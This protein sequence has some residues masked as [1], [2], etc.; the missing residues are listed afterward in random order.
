MS[1]TVLIN[2][3]PEKH[4]RT[5]AHSLVSQGLASYVGSYDPRPARIEVLRREWEHAQGLAD[6][7]AASLADDPDSAEKAHN[8]SKLTRAAEVA[9][10]AWIDAR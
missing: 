6:W 7:A 1:L 9:R 5:M 8:L 4:T 10:R 2:G 3:K